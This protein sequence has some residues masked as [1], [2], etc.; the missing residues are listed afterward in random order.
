LG[1]NFAVNLI[2]YLSKGGGC[3]MIRK[4]VFEGRLVE[5]RYFHTTRLGRGTIYSTE[6]RLSS[7]DKDRIIIDGTTPWMLENKLRQLLPALI[8]SREAGVGQI[9]NP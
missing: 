5:L 4:K 1:I 7:S 3:N 6:V 2:T 8:Q 9:G